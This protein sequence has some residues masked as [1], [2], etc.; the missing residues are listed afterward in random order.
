[1]LA[2]KT[3]NLFSYFIFCKVTAAAPR[4]EREIRFLVDS[5]VEE[6]ANRVAGAGRWGRKSNDVN[7]RPMSTDD[8]FS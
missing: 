6:E 7:K 8:A 1:L 2:L 4:V 3:D 5:E